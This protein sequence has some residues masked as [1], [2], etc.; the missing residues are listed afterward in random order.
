MS[1]VLSCRNE[2]WDA[3][4]WHPAHSLQIIPEYQG[5]R[6]LTKYED[7]YPAVTWNK[8]NAVS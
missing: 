4:G 3:G 5:S 6:D 2:S 7:I 1:Q 8:D